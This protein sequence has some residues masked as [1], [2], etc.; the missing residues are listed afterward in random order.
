M[1]MKEIVVKIK[2]TDDLIN[3][4]D[5]EKLS[6]EFASYLYEEGSSIPLHQK[7]Q[8]HFYIPSILEE[9]RLELVD[10]IRAHFGMQVRSSLVAKD[11]ER[12][13]EAI[14]FLIGT[15][16]VLFSSWLE[17]QTEFLFGELFM[18]AGWVA[19]WEAVYSIFFT[20]TK[21]KL[22]LKRCRKLAS[23]HVEFSEYEETACK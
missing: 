9:Q 11:Y 2:H 15:I 12:M 8:I 10:H 4:F 23:C 21:T 20:Q 14:L 13:K 3:P 6:P 19:I 17:H 22:R 1:S 16:F 18:I 7:F 5:P